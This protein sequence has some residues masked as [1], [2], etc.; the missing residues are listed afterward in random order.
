MTWSTEAGA[1]RDA[2]T[3]AFATGHVEPAPTETL[4]PAIAAGDRC[5]NC[6]SPLASDQRY[7]LECGERRGQARF[8]AVLPTKSA[9]VVRTETARRSGPRFTSATTLIAGVGTLLLAMGIGVLIGRSNGGHAAGNSTVRVVN[10]GGGTGASTAAAASTP[11]TAAS[12]GAKKKSNGKHKGAS[13]ASAAN[14]TQTVKSL[15]PPT[16][17]IG[18]TGTGRGYSN[19]H[20]TGKFFGPGG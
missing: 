13:N 9:A 16:V 18:A 19:G 14:V 5:A 10:L 20:F 12:T 3:E 11:T 2:P 8:N 17:T 4:A 6:G 1:S 15:P 7:C